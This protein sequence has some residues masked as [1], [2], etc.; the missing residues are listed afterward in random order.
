MHLV[1]T[2]PA[3]GYVLDTARKVLQVPDLL[4][5]ADVWLPGSELEQGSRARG[6]LTGLESTAHQ[7]RRPNLPCPLALILDRSGETHSQ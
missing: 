3:E 1:A 2:G 6:Q 4:E 7:V 5:L